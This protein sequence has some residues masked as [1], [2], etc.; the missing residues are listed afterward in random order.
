MSWIVQS[1]PCCR[2]RVCRMGRFTYT[3][4]K[5]REDGVEIRDWI[6]D[7]ISMSRLGVFPRDPQLAAASHRPTR[8]TRL[9]IPFSASTVLKLM[10]RAQQSSPH[11]HSLTK[12][13]ESP[14]ARIRIPP[15]HVYTLPPVKPCA[16]R[17]S[18]HQH[19]TLRSQVQNNGI[20]PRVRR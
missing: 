19:H 18:Q 6:G 13:E 10:D 14:T 15:R 7:A 20:R 17:L 4:E 11:Q 8:L 2:I 16:T 3:E 1:P 9:F 5:W 12:L